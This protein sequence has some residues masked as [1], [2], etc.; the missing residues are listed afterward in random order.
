MNP[1]ALSFLI[2][3]NGVGER[4][5][6]GSRCFFLYQ[7]SLYTSPL[8]SGIHLAMNGTGLIAQSVCHCTS[9]SFSCKCNNK[10]GIFVKANCSD[11]GLNVPDGN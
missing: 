1:A 10:R 8:W 11:Y 9:D 2:H 7:S 4:D 3:G 6:R 5:V